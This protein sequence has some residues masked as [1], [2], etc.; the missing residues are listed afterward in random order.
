V[1]YDAKS[2]EAFALYPDTVSLNFNADNIYAGHHSVSQATSASG[3]APKL[4]LLPDVDTSLADALEPGG[5]PMSRL[6][7]TYR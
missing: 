2:W 4:N 7:W 1:P 3:N 6:I 5:M